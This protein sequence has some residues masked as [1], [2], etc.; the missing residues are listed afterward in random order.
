M[1]KLPVIII[2][3]ALILVGLSFVSK[4]AN[5]LPPIIEPVEIIDQTLKK[6]TPPK[7]AAK[8]Q[9]PPTVQTPVSIPPATTQTTQ[10]VTPPPPPPPAV[11]EIKTVSYTDSG[12]NPSSVSIKRGETVKFRND[13]SGGMQVASNVH[14]VHS[15]YSGF[16]A[17]RAYGQGETYS[18]TFDRTGSWN[19]HNHVNAGRGGQ[20]VVE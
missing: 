10:S 12:F 15:D 8:P 19:Y 16:D 3:L 17:G 14:P 2:L 4:P 13:S 1:N 20:V 7:P 6:E 11:P 9:T 5:D 18:F